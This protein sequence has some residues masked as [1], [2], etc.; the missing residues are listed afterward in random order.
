MPKTHPLAERLKGTQIAETLNS[1]SMREQL[2]EHDQLL[3]ERRKRSCFN[4]LKEGEFWKFQCSYKYELGKV[5]K[6]K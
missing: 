6:Y 2:K 5:D 3:I 1:E 4:C